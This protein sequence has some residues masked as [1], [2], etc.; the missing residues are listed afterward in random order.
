V[1]VAIGLHHVNQQHDA[2]GVF[3]R[4]IGGPFSGAFYRGG[5]SADGKVLGQDVREAWKR[6]NA[7]PATE[8]RPGA[9][10]VG[11]RGPVDAEHAEPVP[12]PRSLALQL[13]YRSLA[14]G[15]EGQLRLAQP[16]DFPNARRFYIYEAQPGKWWLTETEWKALIPERP[17]PGKR[18]PAPDGVRDQLVRRF[19]NPTL[20]FG[21]V[22]AWR[23]EDVRAAELR[24]IVEEAS[25]EHL[26]L[27]V[28]GHALLGKTFDPDLKV[29][30]KDG[31]PVGVGYEPRLWGHLKYN[32]KSGHFTRFEVV[33]L[34]EYYGKLHGSFFDVYRPGRQPVGIVFQLAEENSPVAR[35][36]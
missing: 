13:Y 5:V 18:F 32:R 4:K 19:L 34:G 3:L 17:E 15:P 25:P 6:W 10:Q 2:E 33:A 28:E 29:E 11:E 24:L 16:K 35:G 20:A 30:L 27:R 21:A 31:Q 23:K 36:H 7:L 8:R 1:P 12:P 14:Y 22:G 26:Q 9:V